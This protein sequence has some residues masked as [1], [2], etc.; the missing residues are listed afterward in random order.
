MPTVSSV[1]V[2]VPLSNIAIKYKN[3]AFVAERIAPIVPVNKEADRYYIFSREE[4]RDMDSLRAAGAEANE[5]DWDVTSATYTAEEYALKHLLPA[6][7]VANAD[8]AIQPKINTTQK[9]SKWINLGF[10]KRVQAIAQNVANVGGNHT[11]VTK[12]DAAAGQDPEAD[13]D[14]AKNSIRQTAGVNPNTILMSETVWQALRRWLK[15]QATNAT[16][17]DWIEIGKAPNR[18]WDLDLIVAGSVENTSDEGQADSISDIWNDNVVVAYVEKS[19]SLDSLTFIYTFRAR[20]FR[21]KT[22]TVEERDGEMIEVGVIQDERLI[23]S[24]AGYL[25]VDALT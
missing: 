23:A 21:T 20:V 24:D 9:L 3:P 12:W 7:V 2:S 25:M 18:I 1:H 16:Y 5:V 6:R 19:P 22:W 15:S 13:V 14:T 8:P 17:R 11:V 10:E 4:L